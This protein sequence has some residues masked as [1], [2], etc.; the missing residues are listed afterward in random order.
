MNPIQ[1]SEKDR[2]GLN[3]L[4]AFLEP[5]FNHSNFEYSKATGQGVNDF[6]CL[7]NDECLTNPRSQPLPGTA[8]PRGSAS[9]Q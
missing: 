4:M 3:S 1:E 7:N 9:I 6:E 2:S 8:L 5:I